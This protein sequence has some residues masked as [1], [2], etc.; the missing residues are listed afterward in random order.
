MREPTIS[1]R[2]SVSL[3]VPLAAPSDFASLVERGGFRVA[4]MGDAPWSTDAVSFQSFLC[5][6]ANAKSLA[7]ATVS[8]FNSADEPS[9]VSFFAYQRLLRWFCFPGDLKLIRQLTA[10]LVENGATKSTA[11]IAEAQ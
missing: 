8:V 2:H 7:V 5:G 1:Q 11:N 9:R 4:P 6:S 10:W 3:S